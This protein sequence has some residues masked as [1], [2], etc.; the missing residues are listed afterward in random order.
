MGL[1][2]TISTGRLWERASV[3]MFSASMRLVTVDFSF[4]KQAWMLFLILIV[5]LDEVVNNVFCSIDARVI[6]L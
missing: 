2:R 1:Y 6:A 3:H 5:V 4:V